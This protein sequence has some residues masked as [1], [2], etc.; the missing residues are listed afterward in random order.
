MTVQ[1]R[2]YR[3]HCFFEEA[4]ADLRSALARSFYD[5]DYNTAC[6][7]EI[8]CEDG[9]VLSYSEIVDLC[10]WSC[11]TNA[12]IVEST[13]AAQDTPNSSNLGQF[14]VSC[15]KMGQHGR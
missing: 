2:Y 1:Y 10:G 6:P 7:H 11:G 4:E 5:I 9:S 15:R 3:Y 14:A 12:M 8:V 13:L